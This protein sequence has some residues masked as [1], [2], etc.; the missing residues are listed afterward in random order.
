[1]QHRVF[2]TSLSLSIEAIASL[3]LIHLY[4]QK[5][6]GRFQL[7]TQLLPSNYI[8]KS[9]LKSRHSDSNNNHQ[10][11]LEKLTFKQQLK[12]KSPVVD[13]NNRLNGVFPLFIS[14]SSEFSPGE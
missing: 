10:L 14:L 13:A 5:L 1:M 6:G 12:L 4:L 7:R 8:I 3:I 9:L 11:T 2:Y